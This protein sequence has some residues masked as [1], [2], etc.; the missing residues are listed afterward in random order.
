MKY[1]LISIFIVQVCAEVIC[2][3]KSHTWEIQN[4]STRVYFENNPASF[5]IKQIKATTDQGKGFYMLLSFLA[6]REIHKDGEYVQ[7]Y[8]LT[9]KWNFTCDK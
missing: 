2:D 3:S 7:A 8:D 4:N 1:L 5:T 6:V 9:S